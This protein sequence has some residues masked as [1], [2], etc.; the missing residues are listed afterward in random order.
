L[1][2]PSK[3]GQYGVKAAKKGKTASMARASNYV[4]KKRGLNE[5]A[6]EKYPFHKGGNPSK[7][8]PLAAKF[9]SFFEEN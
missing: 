4:V 2:P 7:K 9:T 8:M 1:T 3:Y 6:S 5:N